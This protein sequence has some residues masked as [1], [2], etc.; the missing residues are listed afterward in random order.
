MASYIIETKE[1]TDTFLISGLEKEEVI[2]G[3][4]WLQRYNPN[5]DWVTG[6]TTFLP[7]QYVKIP[8][9]CGILDFESPEELIKRI[10]IR[11]KLSTSQQLEH[12][13]ER[14]SKDTQGTISTYLAE[15][16]A[17]FEDRVAE[18]FLISRSYDH[19]I[20]LKLEFTPRDCKIYLLM[21]LEQTE[22]DQFLTENL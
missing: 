6:R 12:G 18:Q 9:V 5:V 16:H 3:L 10:D 11:A 13:T 21:A 14:Q 19:A 17:Q 1:M 15:Y 20:E 8:Q 4:P 22:L 7:R 2:L